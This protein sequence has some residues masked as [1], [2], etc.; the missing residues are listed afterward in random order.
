MQL[1]PEEYA[2]ADKALAR[3][4]KSARNWK[5]GLTAVLML[6][7][8]MTAIGGLSIIDALYQVHESKKYTVDKLIN[9][10]NEIPQGT[11]RDLWMVGT[12]RKCALILEHKFGIYSLATVQGTVGV[13]MV[14]H[15]LIIVGLV[16]MRW[17]RGAE[18]VLVAKLLR[19]LLSNYSNK[20]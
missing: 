5:K 12:F 7:I 20:E 11:Y 4:G 15:G 10:A 1:L 16:V 3:F 2:L 13:V 17:N 19:N 14:M 6:S 8:F 9:D 18:R